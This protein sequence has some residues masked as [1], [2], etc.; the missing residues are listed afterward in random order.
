MS[1]KSSKN[2]VIIRSKSALAIELSK[3]EGFY[4]GKV[5]LEQYPTPSEIAAD[6]LWNAYYLGD[7]EGKVIV[8]LGSGTGILGIGAL[9]LGA[10]KVY[11]VDIDESAMNIAKTNFSKVESESSTI[12]D[13][14]F[15][16]GDIGEFKVKVDTI[17]E[18]PPFGVK[19]RHNDR[20]FLE[21]AFRL[22]NI[23]YSLHKSET[24]SYLGG[25]SDKKSFDIS[26]E[27]R[28]KFGLSSTMKFHVKKM[29]YID[30]S[31]FRFSRRENEVK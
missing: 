13:T 7:I 17:V 27:Y 16:L 24:K 4:E 26:H 25:F 3:L 30:V 6:L 31:C 19:V 5:R 9:L 22:G 20:Y 2:R 18:N 29:H 28:Y 23:V 15:I 12:G 8:D 1:V 14:E 10:K 11:F 21:N